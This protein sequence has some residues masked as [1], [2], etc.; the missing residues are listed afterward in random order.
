M[1]KSIRFLVV[2]DEVI[3]AMCLEMELKQAGYTV[4]RRVVSGEEAVIA[5]KQYHPD[6]ILMDI[7]LAGTLDGIEAARQIRAES[8]IPIL[9]MTGYPDHA[10]LERA[11]QQ[12][13]LAVLSKPILI[14]DIQSAIASIEHPGGMDAE[15]TGG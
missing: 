7:R 8:S 5:A 9:F 4:L 1:T 6:V 14:Q 11:K 12:N 3:I 2:E 10:V 15:S 13:P